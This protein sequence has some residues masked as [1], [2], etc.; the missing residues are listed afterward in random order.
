MEE[1]K[2]K[3]IMI[4]VIIACFAVAGIYTYSRHS[5]G[6]GGIDDIPE[7]EMIWVKCNNPACKAEYQMGKKAYFKYVQEHVQPMAPT[8]PPLVCKECGEQSGYWAEK[9][10]NPDCG[11]VFLRGAVPNDHADR[12]PKCGHSETEEIREARKRERAAGGTE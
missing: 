6:G 8:A 11:I 4:G 12:C 1:S 3:P 2:K 10:T 5:G 9:C 7:G